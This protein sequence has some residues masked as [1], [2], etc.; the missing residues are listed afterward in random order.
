MHFSLRFC[1]GFSLYLLA[2]NFSLPS[3]PIFVCF[4]P[5]CVSYF[6]LSLLLFVVSRHVLTFQC[7]LLFSYSTSSLFLFVASSLCC[8]CCFH[9]P[10][11]SV[12][13]ALFHI[14]KTVSNHFSPHRLTP[15]VT[16]TVGQCQCDVSR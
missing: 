8:V 4:S 14:K 9:L 16:D 13:L 3:G 6:L 5:K 15:V 12:F 2:F 7:G 10:H 1:F 11:F